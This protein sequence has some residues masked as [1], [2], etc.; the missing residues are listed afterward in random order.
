M[1]YDKLHENVIFLRSTKKTTNNGILSQRFRRGQC[2]RS[3]HIQKNYYIVS[4]L[5]EK[6]HSPMLKFVHWSVSNTNIL[7]VDFFGTVFT[8]HLLAQ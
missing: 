8:K 6:E 3:C 4:T 2:V 7:F 5:I 1:I